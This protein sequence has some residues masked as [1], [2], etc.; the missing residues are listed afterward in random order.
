M[1][2]EITMYHCVSESDCMKSISYQLSAI[3]K[4]AGGTECSNSVSGKEQRGELCI[5]YSVL[6]WRL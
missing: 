3:V 1:C 2:K 4:D 6:K 5:T